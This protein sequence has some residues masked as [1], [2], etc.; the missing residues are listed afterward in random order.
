M[1]R[2]SSRRRSS[3]PRRSLDWCG[4]RFWGLNEQLSQGI[5]ADGSD[6]EVA[7]FWTIWPTGQEDVNANPGI[8]PNV[9]DQTLTKSLTLVAA[10]TGNGGA[11][12]AMNP[13]SVYFGLI[14]WEAMD[15]ASID[16]LITTGVVPNPIDPSQDWIWRNVMMAAVQ[17]V[18][19]YSQTD[20]QAIVSKAQRKMPKQHGILLVVSS[21]AATPNINISWSVDVRHLVKKAP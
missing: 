9:P 17:N 2:F 10:A 3:S 8:R 14:L 20:F 4:S 6:S 18:V 13:V 5:Q 11:Q 19:D 21:W 1:K 15:P 7:S 12:V 16:Q